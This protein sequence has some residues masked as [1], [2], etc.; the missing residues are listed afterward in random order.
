M[1]G[2]FSFSRHPSQI[3][4]AVKPI[5]KICPFRWQCRLSSPTIHRRWILSTL[6]SSSVIL[7][8]DPCMSPCF[9]PMKDSQCFYG[10]CLS[11][12]GH[13]SRQPL[14][15]CHKLVQIP[16]K[17][18]LRSKFHQFVDSFVTNI[19]LMSQRS[20]QLNFVMFGH[21]HE[22]SMAV[23]NQFWVDLVIA[24]WVTCCLTIW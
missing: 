19:T 20:Y 3:R 18:T 10:L 13:R 16:Y 7:A 21:L 4:L 14:L 6:N 11:S 8:E 5:L 1:C 23:P 9:S 15:I 2:W 12:P 22:G 17:R 24:K